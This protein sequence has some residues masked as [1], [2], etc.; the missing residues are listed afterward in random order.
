MLLRPGGA[1][2]LRV[3]DVTHEQV[4]EGV[5]ALLSDGRTTL[6]TH[7]L[8]P[9]E[10]V[11]EQLGFRRSR[12]PIWLSGPSQKTF[13]TTAASWSRSFSSIGSASRRAA[14]IPCTDSGSRSSLASSP[15]SSTIRANS[16]A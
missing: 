9:L 5:L 15:S 12:P 11:Q 4:A 2:D 13:P 3:G 7:E 10:P 1:R 6:A 14:M 8:L 16:S